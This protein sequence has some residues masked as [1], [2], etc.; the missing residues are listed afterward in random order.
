[1]KKKTWHT[2]P[3]YLIKS[4][5]LPICFKPILFKTFWS[6]S[7]VVLL[8]YSAHETI[9]LILTKQMYEKRF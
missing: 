4:P 5:V 6:S 1:M 2:L 7:F 9:R 3:N 8:K